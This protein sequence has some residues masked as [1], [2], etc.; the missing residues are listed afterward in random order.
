VDLSQPDTLRTTIAAS[1]KEICPNEWEEI[2]V[3]NNAATLDPIGPTSKKAADR[4]LANINTNFAS[5]ILAL[6]L[7]VAHFQEARCR[8][9]IA[10]ISSGA[11]R[12]SYYGWSLYCAAKAGIEAYIEVL[13]LEQQKEKTPFIPINIDPNV[14]DT[15]MQALIRNTCP[16]DF[17]D[18]NRFQRRKTE[19]DLATPEAVAQQVLGIIDKEELTPGARYEV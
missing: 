3:I 10:S 18:V 7:I 1:L 17:P 4:V 2:L 16:D 5:P 9:V 13:A 15:E 12:K 8:K 19:G 11:A 6:S 14:I